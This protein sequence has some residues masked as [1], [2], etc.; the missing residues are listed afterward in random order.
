VDSKCKVFIV[1]DDSA[2]RNSVASLVLSRGLSVAT[3]PSAMEF[4]AASTASQTG[5]VVA[6]LRMPAMT[7][8]ELQQELKRRG[9]DIPVI[10][11]TGHGDVR[12]AVQAMQAGAFTFLE[13][14]CHNEELWSTICA[15]L[16]TAAAQEARH[17]EH[18][19]TLRRLLEL[20]T[21]ER[22]VYQAMVAGKPNKLIAAELDIS[23][24]TVELRRAQ[25][26]RKMGAATLADLV[27]MAVASKVLNTVLPD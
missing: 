10:L 18:A 3:F 11:I 17:A 7:G 15:A 16:D 2:A 20:T 22:Y 12:T 23:L 27:R 19:E 5:C 8:L 6:D 21:Q 26:L 13:K 1:D 4:L 14:P 25:V 24:R 9:N